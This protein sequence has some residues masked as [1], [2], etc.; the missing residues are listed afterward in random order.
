[1]RELF[2]ELTASLPRERVVA[3]PPAVGGDPP[4]RPDEALTLEP[5]ERGIQR[6]LPQLQD[7][8]SDV[9]ALA[10][11]LCAL[12]PE[13]SALV[14]VSDPTSGG[15][16]KQAETPSVARVVAILRER[17]DAIERS[18]KARLPVPASDVLEIRAPCPAT[19]GR[20]ADLEA[21]GEAVRADVGDKTGVFLEWE[22]KRI[23]RAARGES[24]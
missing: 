12:A 5:I 18:R 13:V 3:R 22:I 10:P 7:V 4:L 20:A 21:L 17:A 14:S 2:A 24:D 6:A 1:M 16:P 15:A 8:G 19:E 9:S 11:E 23:G